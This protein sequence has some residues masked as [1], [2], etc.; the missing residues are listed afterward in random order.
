MRISKIALIFGIAAPFLVSCGNNNYKYTLTFYQDHGNHF[1]DYNVLTTTTLD[2]IKTYAGNLRDYTKKGYDRSWDWENY[3][4]DNQTSDWCI[5]ALYSYHV[6]KISFQYNNVEVGTSSYTMV[7][8]TFVV[9]QMTPSQKGFKYAFDPVEVKGKTED[10]VIPL[11]LERITYTLSFYLNKEDT[12]PTKVDYSYDEPSVTAPNG[13][14]GYTCKWETEDESI[15]IDA[16]ATIDFKSTYGEDML[17]NYSLYLKKTPI[18]YTVNLNVNGGS[19]SEETSLEATYG[20]PIT[21]P[22]PTFKSGAKFLGWFD[23]TSGELVASGEPYNVPHDSTLYARYGIDF[24]NSTDNALVINGSRNCI[25]T[26]EIDS[27]TKTSGNNSFKIKT[28]GSETFSC[29]FDLDFLTS[30]F[31]DPSVTALN[32]DAKCTVPSTKFSYQNTTTS[33]YEFDCCNK[34]EQAGYGLDTIWKT[35]SLTR[36]MYNNATN[37]GI[38]MITVGN[39]TPIG[40]YFWIDN[41]RPS[42]EKVNL[43]GFEGSRLVPKVS[44]PTQWYYYSAS[45]RNFNNQEI[46]IVTSKQGNHTDYEFDYTNKTEGNRS[47]R[48]HKTT[49]TWL[50]IAVL[51]VPV[52]FETV[53]IDIYVTVD[54]NSQ[55]TILGGNAKPFTTGVIKANE[56]H[57]YTLTK[58][59][60][61]YSAPVY[62]LISLSG[63]PE[64]DMYIDNIRFN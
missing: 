28:K 13:P 50:N 55:V 21:L 31:N 16:G 24:E 47:L 17:G 22:T 42:T 5:D 41:V 56:W 61:S 48:F 1:D 49:Q 4:F 32:F 63:S 30:A 51:N 52:E 3:D 37:K 7:D 18:K 20:E 11:R 23:S 12:N 33:P 45:Y 64:Y 38:L 6:Y 57:T 35:F 36:E 14:V 54:L 2:E 39:Q 46:V 10:I 27:T 29:S 9:P 8:S 19:M 59:N 53:T 34:G 62:T 40:S 43:Y 44:D 26:R 60:Y 58:D 15:V 25:D